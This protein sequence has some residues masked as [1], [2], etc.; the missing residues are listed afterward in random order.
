MH[1][2]NNVSSSFRDFEDGLQYFSAVKVVGIEAIITRNI[3]DFKSSSIPVLTPAQ[4]LLT[5][6]R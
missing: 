5:I 3:R 1:F 2:E 4:F 6:E